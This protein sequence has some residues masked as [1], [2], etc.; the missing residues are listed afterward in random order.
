MTKEANP[1]LARFGA[2]IARSLGPGLGGKVMG[3]AIPKAPIQ[4]VFLRPGAGALAK[5][6]GKALTPESRAAW[7]QARS[8]NK[9]WQG[10]DK[11]HEA[12]V[13]Q[14]LLQHGN[15]LT[16]VGAAGVGTIGGLG[17]AYLGGAFDGEQR[18]P[19]PP[20]LG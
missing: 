5:P 18:P 13:Q 1:L 11:A 19:A 9:A 7:T 17:A 4:P 20:M 2:L 3:G 8:Q 14:Q 12:M 16:G 15:R 6:A 10:Y